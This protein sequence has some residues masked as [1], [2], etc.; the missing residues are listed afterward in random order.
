LDRGTAKRNTFK[1]AEEIEDLG[2]SLDTFNGRNSFGLTAKGLRADLPKLMDLAADCMLHPNFD[3]EELEK[4]RADT[5]QQ[6][7]QED[8]SLFTLNSKILRPLLF[9]DHPYARQTLGTPETVKKIS[10]DDLKKMHQ[11]WVQPENIAISFV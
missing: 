5:L 3:K 2:G 10:A 11:A 9:G 8:E 1:I 4:L 6:I 7:A